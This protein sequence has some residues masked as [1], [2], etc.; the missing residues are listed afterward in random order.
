[1]K[2]LMLDRVRK[3]AAHEDCGG[4]VDREG[5]AGY[6]WHR[7]R[8]QEPC[9]NAREATRVASKT[10]RATESWVAGTS[11]LVPEVDPL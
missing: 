5:R 1:M 3:A 9:D 11:I 6:N 4:C 2:G 8:G 7:K 10:R